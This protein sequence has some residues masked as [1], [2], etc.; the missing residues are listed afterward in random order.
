MGLANETAADDELHAT[1]NKRA[2]DLAAGPRRAIA[3]TKQ[4][5]RQ[6][7]DADLASMLE[8]EALAQGIAA[9]TEDHLSRRAAFLAR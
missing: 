4:L 6:A 3:L 5:L 8:Q 1:A 9:V 2:A 7:A